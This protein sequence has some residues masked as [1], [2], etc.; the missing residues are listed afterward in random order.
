[1]LPADEL[2][3]IRTDLET[4]LPDT[5]NILSLTRSSDSQGGW[6]ET[7]GTAGTTI[8]CRVDFIGGAEAVTGG[9]L[10]PYSRAIV[11]LPQATTITAQNRIEH[12]GNTYTVQAV[13]L[14]SWLGVKRASVEKL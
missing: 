12:G 11:T 9:A 4:T 5:C 2:A 13:N 8:A 6:S 14:G 10:I 1:M 3:Q 7:W